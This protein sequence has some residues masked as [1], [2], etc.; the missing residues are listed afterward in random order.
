MAISPISDLAPPMQTTMNATLT[1]IHEALAQ[2]VH[3][4]P[5]YGC[6]R[7]GRRRCLRFDRARVRAAGLR[8]DD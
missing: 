5:E 3:L 6:D 1:L 4:A 7:M 8:C 2:F